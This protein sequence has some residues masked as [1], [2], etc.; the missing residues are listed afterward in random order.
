MLLLFVMSLYFVFLF[1]QNA[2]EN[3]HEVALAR[4]RSSRGGSSWTRHLELL[5]LLLAAAVMRGVFISARRVQLLK[6]ILFRPG[7]CL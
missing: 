5:L 4:T 2:S 6:T 1:L 3:I 7:G